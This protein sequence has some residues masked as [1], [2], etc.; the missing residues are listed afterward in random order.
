MLLLEASQTML[1]TGLPNNH[2]SFQ[3]LK[4]KLTTSWNQIHS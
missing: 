4:K 2:T 1:K 3:L